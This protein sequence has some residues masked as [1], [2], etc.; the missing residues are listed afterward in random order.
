M[1][2][3][4]SEIILLTPTP[5]ERLGVSER[6][7]GKVFS[8]L[9]PTV[10]ESGPGKINA[11][12]TLA[13]ELASRRERGSPPAFA[14]GVGTCGSLNKSLRGGEMVA[15]LDCVISDWRHEDGKENLTGPYGTFDYGRLSPD[16]LE[17]MAIR[18]GNPVLLE[19]MDILGKNGFRIGRVLT[20]DAFVVGKEHKLSLGEAFGALVCDMESGAFALA[21]RKLGDVPWLNIR[22]VADT[23]DESLEDYFKVETTM[24][25]ILGSKTLEILEILNGLLEK[26]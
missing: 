22:I 19:L 14:A 18:C 8:K 21:A 10:V 20:S 7:E 15:S 5:G 3:D 13:R 23:L 2:S 6:L 16:R 11:A 26:A 12:M 25:D 4:K 17:G 9:Y 24:A 1:T